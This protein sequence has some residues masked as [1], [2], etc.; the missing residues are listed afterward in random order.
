MKIRNDFVSNS[1]SSSFII[2]GQQYTYDQ[3]K[4]MICNNPKLLEYINKIYNINMNMEDYSDD[5][6][7]YD[8]C[9]NIIEF[10]KSDI[11]MEYLGQDYD[12][13]VIFGLNPIDKMK[14]DETLSQFKNRVLNEILK[15]GFSS[16]IKNIN[17]IKGGCTMNGESFVD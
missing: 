13:P 8:L 10:V 16:E 11:D 14:D 5:I 1:S 12:D 9:F 17:F 4:Q 6:D 15:L 3:I 2:V 7:L